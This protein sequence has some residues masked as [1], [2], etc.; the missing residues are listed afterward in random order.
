[1]R[2]RNEGRDRLRA[3]E[4]VAQKF[5][6]LRPASEVLTAVRAVPTRFA[7]FDHATRVG[8]FPIERFSLLHG[9]SN[10]GK[11]IFALGIADSFL[12]RDHFV[13]YIDAERTTPITWVRQLLGSRTEHPGFRAAKPDT[14]EKTI[15]VV[16]DFLN[17]II[18]S[19]DSLPEDTGAVIIVDSLRKLVPAGLMKEI[20]AEAKEEAEATKKARP[21]QRKPG[22]TTGR[23]RKAQLQARMNA[24][25][26]DEIVPHLE[27]AS[28]GMLAIAREMVDPNNTNMWAIAQGEN[29]KVGGGGAPY[30]DASLSMRTQRERW[31]DNGASEA[32][33][34]VIYGERH[35]L[36][37]K[38]TKIGGKDDKVTRCRFH[39]SN[40]NHVPFGF[41]RARDV[42][43]LAGK[44][45][46]VKRPKGA[47]ITWDSNRWQGDNKAVLAL[48]ADP[49]KLARL[50]AEVRERF[51]EQR[52]DEQARD[53]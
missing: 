49:A 39:T 30:Y 23:D 44:F 21:G 48:T 6:G 29:Y 10:E 38:K 52:P 22:I 47:W 34:R 50:E 35:L 45:E 42:L 15:E 17:T 5:K 19:R 16:R 4:A 24:A 41:D 25:W 2:T 53:S 32:K 37:I 11:S 26:M 7:Q 46:V 18:K 36:T 28:A 9:P 33:D 20:L 3:L 51:A 31:V 40:G 12:A 1:M 14:Y 13:L 43:E 8:G 27:M